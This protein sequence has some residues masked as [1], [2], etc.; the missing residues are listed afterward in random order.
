MKVNVEVFGSLRDNVDDYDPDRGI[1][2]EVPPATNVKDLLALLNIPFSECGMVTVNLKLAEE[3]DELPDRASVV[4][5]PF[6]GG[7]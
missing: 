1:D 5:L 2:V 6:V 7:G 3:E 4:V